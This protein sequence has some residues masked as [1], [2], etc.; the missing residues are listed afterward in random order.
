M[1]HSSVL[2]GLQSENTWLEIPQANSV[3]AP[4]RTPDATAMPSLKPS[5]ATWG[6]WSPGSGEAALSS[7]GVSL[8]VPP[9]SLS[10]IGLDLTQQPEPVSEPR[11]PACWAD[12]RAPSPGLS[13]TPLFSLRPPATHQA[14]PPAHSALTPP[15]RAR[16]S[17]PVTSVRPPLRTTY[18]AIMS[19]PFASAPARGHSHVPEQRERGPEEGGTSR[20]SR[21]S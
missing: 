1:G 9:T 16:E 4:A 2:C 15:Q 6:R 18:C 19:G 13:G 12:L 14:P 5:V 3:P 21:P 17:H 8:R 7:R 20:D 10:A 11:G